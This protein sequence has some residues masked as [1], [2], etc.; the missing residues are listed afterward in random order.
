MLCFVMLSVGATF[1][2][3]N[4]TDV[5]AIDDEITID[6]PLAVEQDV[7]EVSANESSA[8]V[9]TPETIGQ[10]IDD[11]GQLYKNVTADEIVFNGTFDNL[12]LTVER[13]ITLTGGFFND[14]NFEIYSSDVILRNLSIIQNKGVNSIFVAGSEENHTSDVLIDN[15][16]IVFADDQSGAGAI[17]IEV[18]YSDDFMFINS[19]IAYGGR[20]NG[21]Y[22][23]N[24]VR[25]TSSKNAII[26]NNEILFPLLL[27]GLKS[28][29]VLAIG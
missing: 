24:A 23:N 15:V 12:N 29:Q 2:A 8:A 5:I 22:I 10:Y 28:L 6:E 11:S 26:F 4:A 18:M 9:V 1:A 16:N 14:P 20:T 13:A 3:D 19:F 7:Q 27:D 21:Y 25:I 17:P